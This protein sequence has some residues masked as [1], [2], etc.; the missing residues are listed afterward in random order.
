MTVPKSAV[1]LAFLVICVAVVVFE[2]TL[3]GSFIGSD[4]AYIH[5]RYIQNLRTGNGFG[6]NPDRPSNGSTSPLWVVFSA[7][8]T[9]ALR[10][11]DL[12]VAV[13]TLNTLL[14]VTS[15]WV[16]YLLLLR[17]TPSPWGAIV[18]TWRMHRIL[19]CSN[20]Q[21]QQWKPVLFPY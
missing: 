15:I 21:D 4:D 18:G 12:P 8:T 19:G 5:L 2:F 1:N 10:D 14:F 9:Y 17:L 20:G 11:I 7:A 13:K 16:F 3:N 6:F